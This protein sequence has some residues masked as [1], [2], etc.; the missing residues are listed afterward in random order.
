MNEKLTGPILKPKSGKI[1]NIIIFLHGYG[2]NGNDLIEIGKSWF[3]YIPNTLF[4]SPNAPFNCQWS[5][6]AFQWFDL[7]S[8]APEKIGQGIKIAGPFLNDFIDQNIETYKIDEN[9]I[10]YVGFSQGAMMALHHICKRKKK[11]AGIL[12][13][14]GMLFE[15]KDFD[16]EVISTFP[17]RLYHGI[18]DE[19]ISSDFSA[20]ANEKLKSL[21][22]DI[23]Y[24]LQKNLGHGIDNF[25]LDY[26]LKFIKKIF[27]I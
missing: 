8:I 14:S 12:A 24:H 21:G 10:F 2:A 19:V 6:D 1:E 7:T 17:I 20:K 4:V 23:N 3:Q 15:N 11:C 5:Q 26:G 25:G 16:K 22:F 9:K 13:Y 18:D 27:N